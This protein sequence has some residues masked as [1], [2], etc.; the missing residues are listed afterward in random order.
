MRGLIGFIVMIQ[1]AMGFIGQVFFDGAWGLLPRWFSLP[2][3]AYVGLFAAGAALAVWGDTAKK[4][5][6]QQE[7]AG[8][9]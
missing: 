9:A 2:S 5:K 4:R 3:P 1:G 7:G 8:A 6:Q